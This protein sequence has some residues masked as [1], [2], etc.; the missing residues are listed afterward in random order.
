MAI[1]PKKSKTNG[2]DEGGINLEALMV[3]GAMSIMLNSLL[4]G[5][6][7]E[8]LAPFLFPTLCLFGMFL[9]I[10]NGINKGKSGYMRIIICLKYQLNKLQERIS[11][12]T[13]E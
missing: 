9:L 10:P 3:V 8:K 11:R 4:E 13:Y 5:K 2:G 6:V 1:I 12:H 7:H